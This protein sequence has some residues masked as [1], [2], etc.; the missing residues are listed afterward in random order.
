MRNEQKVMRRDSVVVKTE[1]V[2]YVSVGTQDRSTSTNGPV[3]KQRRSNSD[4]VSLNL[5]GTTP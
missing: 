4:T 5:I 3:V 1:G 2:G